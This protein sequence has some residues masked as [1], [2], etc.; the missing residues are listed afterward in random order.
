MGGWV[1]FVSKDSSIFIKG[2]LSANEAPENPGERKRQESE[3]CVK[4]GS[5]AA[6]PVFLAKEKTSFIWKEVLK[7]AEERVGMCGMKPRGLAQPVFK[8]S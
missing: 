5:R 8:G 2:G 3:H 6:V 4:Q 1:S 7:E